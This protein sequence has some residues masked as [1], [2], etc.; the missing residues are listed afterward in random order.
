MR[1]YTPAVFPIVAA[2]EKKMPFQYVTSTVSAL[3]GDGIVVHV[4]NHSTALRHVRVQIFLNTGAGAS[5]VADSGTVNV[6]AMWQWGLGYTVG[7][8]GEH[9]V[10]IEADKDVLIPKVSFERSTGGTW[11]PF[12]AYTP[13]DFA[14]FKSGQRLW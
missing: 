7:S 4:L 9:W 10:R 12:A 5:Q 8:S 6:T 13:G 11:V 2:M 3:D 1:E 14:V